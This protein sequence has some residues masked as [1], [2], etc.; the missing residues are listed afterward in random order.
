MS[1]KEVIEQFDVTREQI[2][3][4]LE[5]VAQS[6]RAAPVTDQLRQYFAT[7][8]EKSKDI[9]ES[10]HEEILEEAIRSVRPRYRSTGDCPGESAGSRGSFQRQ[11]PGAWAVRPI[12][13]ENRAGGQFGRASCDGFRK[14]LAT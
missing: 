3:A 12:E 10:E 11:Q 14:R 9:P 5:F 7:I 6:L 8:D 4:V 1:V 13:R 2:E